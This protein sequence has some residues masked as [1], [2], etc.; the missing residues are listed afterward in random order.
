[1]QVKSGY[2]F[3]NSGG[4]IGEAR[5]VHELLSAK[6]LAD[7]DDDQVNKFLSCALKFLRR[8]YDDFT[9]VLHG[10]LP[11]RET[12]RRPGDGAGQ[13]GEHLPEPQRGRRYNFTNVKKI[14]EGDFTV[15]GFFALL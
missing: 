11:G 6:E 13:Q 7:D 15:C 4:F 5:A 14:T 10:A 8:L 12:P 9:A 3:L 1:M 2:R